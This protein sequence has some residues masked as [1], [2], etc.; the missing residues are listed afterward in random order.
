MPVEIYKV[1]GYGVMFDVRATSESAAV[2]KVHQ[3]AEAEG[4]LRSAVWSMPARK[5]K[6][7][8]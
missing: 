1:N 4:L 8:R 5:N 3:W 6:V 2:A 7:S